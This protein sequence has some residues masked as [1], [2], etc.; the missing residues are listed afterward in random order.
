MCD[1][2]PKKVT[3]YKYNYCSNNKEI[4][5]YNKKSY[6]V[7]RLSII[8]FLFLITELT[9][10]DE[11]YD[12]DDQIG[13]AVCLPLDKLQLGKPESRTLKFGEV[14]INYLKLNIVCQAA[15][16]DAALNTE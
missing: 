4:G 11:D 8:K 13:E 3:I 9:L 16:A 15:A 2:L 5:Q 7:S 1:Y 6:P 14:S 10:W 12:A